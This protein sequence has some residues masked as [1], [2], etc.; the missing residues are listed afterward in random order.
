VHNVEDR[1]AFDEWLVS[2]PE[3]LDPERQELESALGLSA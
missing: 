1:A 3:Q 2:E